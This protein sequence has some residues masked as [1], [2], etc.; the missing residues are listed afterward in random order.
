LHH[1]CSVL[2]V[3]DDADVREVIS[4][5][6]GNDGYDV[7]A[8]T[9]GRE[10]LDDLRSTPHTCAI[11]LDLMLPQMDGERFR[12]AQLRDR[13]LAAIPLVVLSGAF[14]VRQKAHVLEANAFLMKPGDLEELQETLRRIG[15]AS[16][17][18]RRAGRERRHPDDQFGAAGPSE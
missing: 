3:E 4:L 13:S 17:H 1:R 6:L 14:D 18:P 16:R 15:C 2:V 8:A 7:R 12:A 11:V 10:A 9:N 5:G